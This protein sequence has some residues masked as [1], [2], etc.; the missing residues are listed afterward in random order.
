[1]GG[2]VSQITSLMVVYSTVYSWFTL[3]NKA[4]I[5]IVMVS[6]IC[7]LLDL[8]NSGDVSL[9]TKQWTNKYKHSIY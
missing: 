2:M 8:V 6:N 1:M 3:A 4:S 7:S 5:S 9:K